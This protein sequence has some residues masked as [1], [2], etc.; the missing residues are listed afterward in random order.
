MREAILSLDR[1]S[2]VYGGD[3]D[4]VVAIDG[5]S[6]TLHRGEVVLVVG[7]S[8]SGK[9]TLLSIMG[10]I[11]R[12]SSGTVTVAGVAATEVSER[13]LPRL[14]AANFG[15]IFQHY[16]LFGA[17]TALE[18][19]EMALLMKFG[20]YPNPRQEASHLLEVVG[21]GRR[22][23]HKPAKLSGGER[24]RVAIARALAGNPAVILGDEP[25]AALDT[26]NAMAVVALL[27]DLAHRE[28][29]CV[30]IVSHDFRLEAFA[31]RTIHVQDGRVQSLARKDA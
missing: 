16:H 9:T 22:L 4:R 19:V 14:R 18:N 23:S 21:L 30:V 1:V 12:P 27:R 3:E 15:Y 26:D 17:L 13:R 10:C 31:D 5:V 25:T 11:L 2:K 7:P 28:N 29:R 8:G 20:D 6:L 24:Q